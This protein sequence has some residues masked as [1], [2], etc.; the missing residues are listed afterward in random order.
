MYSKFKNVFKK[1]LAFS[2]GFI[3]VSLIGLGAFLLTKDDLVPFFYRYILGETTDYYKTEEQTVENELDLQPEV[4]YI[5]VA[6][7]AKVLDS[8]NI[9]VLD[10]RE[11]KDYQQKHVSGSISIP[12]ESLDQNYKQLD[13]NK[14]LYVISPCN[15]CGQASDQEISEKLKEL[16]FSK[17]EIINGGI[18]AWQEAGYQFNSK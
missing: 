4:N 14:T 13:K 2:A 16:G 12:Y 9:I 10:T 3:I 7:T 15:S 17:V 11:S 1:I 6:E 18:E 5:S 8:E